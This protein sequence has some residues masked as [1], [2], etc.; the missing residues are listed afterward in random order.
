MLRRSNE[1][2]NTAITLKDETETDKH[3]QKSFYFD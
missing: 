2:I 1:I 3:V